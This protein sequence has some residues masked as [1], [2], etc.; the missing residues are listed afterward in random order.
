M[1]TF[2]YRGYNAQGQKVGGSLRCATRAKAEETVARMDVTDFTV[3]E[4]QTRYSN[5]PYAFVS[6]KELAV[7]C[8]EAATVFGPNDV[9]PAEGIEMLRGHT[10]NAQLKLTLGELSGH[11]ASGI[12]PAG[13]FHMYTHIFGPFLPF[14]IAAGE[15]KNNLRGVLA[16]LSVFFE[17]EEEMRIK[18]FTTLLYP[19]VRMF[20]LWCVVFTLISFCLPTYAGLLS[21]LRVDN[22]LRSLFNISRFLYTHGRTLTLS[23]LLLAGLSYGS[24]WLPATRAWIDKQLAN[25]APFKRIA[26]PVY[27]ARLARGCAL[28]LKYDARPVEAEHCLNQLAGNY[29]LEQKLR[30][31]LVRLRRGEE[32]PSVM[33]A[34]K[35]FPPFF[36]AAFYN[37]VLIG[38]Q[39]GGMADLMHQTAELFTAEAHRLTDRMAAWLEPAMLLT[40]A[41]VAAAP[42]LSVLL[43]LTEAM[44]MLGV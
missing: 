41:L 39:N 9:S 34:D 2:L 8:R 11:L 21:D 15:A 29:N 27:M 25:R 26:M 31:I 24:A 33:E 43:V 10:E 16:D 6:P 4:S 35:Y 20:L 42:L 19:V 5:R 37:R 17:R 30:R 44:R 1:P 12:M 23:A 22:G 32:L 28:M 40:F 38:Y 3:Y 14:M 13:A 18:L 7:F 36:P